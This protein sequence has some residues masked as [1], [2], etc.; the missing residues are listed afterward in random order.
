MP[1]FKA[2]AKIFRRG[3]NNR[4]S[5]PLTKAIAKE[6]AFE[7]MKNDRGTHKRDTTKQQKY[8]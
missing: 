3:K 4:R 5:N 8:N 6:Q 7:D 1:L 2:I